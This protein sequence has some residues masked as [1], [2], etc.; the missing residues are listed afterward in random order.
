MVRHRDRLRNAIQLVQVGSDFFGF[1]ARSTMEVG[2]PGVH[3]FGAIEERRRPTE[4]RRNLA[5]TQPYHAEEKDEPHRPG[6]EQSAVTLER[7]TAT[8]PTQ[9]PVKHV[10]ASHDQPQV[11]SNKFHSHGVHDDPLR[12]RSFDDIQPQRSLHI[13]AFWYL[14]TRDQTGGC[15]RVEQ[16]KSN[17]NGFLEHV[18][19]LPARQAGSDKGPAARTRDL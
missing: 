1:H 8:V 18:G 13:S 6:S 3:K 7:E 10:T 5:A 17:N 11:R 15:D 16:K 4:R 2:L 19:P 14:Q 9:P 12:I